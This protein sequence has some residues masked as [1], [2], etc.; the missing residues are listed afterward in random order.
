MM[1]REVASQ[2]P[3]TLGPGARVEFKSALQA[4]RQGH[5]VFYVLLSWFYHKLEGKGLSGRCATR[6]H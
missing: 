6:V 4:L 5:N 3:Q 2:N 1:Y